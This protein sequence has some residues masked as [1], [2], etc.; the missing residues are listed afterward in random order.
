MIKVKAFFRW[1]VGR[2]LQ[3]PPRYMVIVLA[4]II[5]IS[6]GLIAVLLKNLVHI[7][8]VFIL[9]KFDINS[10][11]FLYFALP[12][13]GIFLT[14]LYVRCF[15]KDDVSHGISKVLYAIAKN[16]GHIKPHNNYSSVIASTLTVAFGGS[17]GLEA[18]VVL[19]GSSIGSSLARFFG[20][21]H[22][23]TILLVG[24]GAAGA[25]AA[26]FKAPITA[27]IFSIEVLMLDLTLS[28]VLPL[29]ISA[30][31]AAS[32]SYLLLGKQAT[33]YFSTQDPFVLSNIPLYVLLGIICGF[34]SLYFSRG[35][36]RIEHW[37]SK[38]TKVYYKIVIGGIVVGV[39]IYLFPPLYGEGYQS[40]KLILTG[41][42]TSLVN[43]SLFYQWQHYTGAFILFLL[44]VVFFKMFASA[45]TTSSGGVG[46]VFAPSL[47]LG[48]VTGYLASLL[49]QKLPFFH[50]SEKNISLVGMAGIMSGVMHAP[51][52]SVFL[53]AEITGGYSLFVPL[54]ITSAI[55]FFTIR[56]F[57]KHSIYTKRLAQKGELRT[58]NKD[59]AILMLLKPK[60]LIE[61]DFLSVL[62]E[63]TLGDLVKLVR[64][65]KRNVFPVIDSK[66]HIVGM[67]L[68]DDIRD[69]LFDG[70]LYPTTYIRELM[71]AP[72]AI[73][74]ENEPMIKIL[75]KFDETGAWNL[76]V[77]DAY[78]QYVGF[79]SKA[80][81]YAT[82]RNLLLEF[83]EE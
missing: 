48:G 82:Y 7:T 15:V 25:I 42:G 65:S 72:P 76:P 30:A 16:H 22:K 39:L 6:T 55:S 62:P 38:I 17:V 52:T 69:L 36:E 41:Q 43:G 71:T 5:G 49:F 24:C 2:T 44:F 13:V 12:L 77:V 18:P 11:N 10:S 83:S 45:L 73:V 28:S 68:L 75:N 4:V 60:P 74:L 59:K 33:F 58:H 50:V 64:Q 26:I 31:T 80:R 19:T 40:L 57:D 67:V 3:L 21:N 27:V 61:R 20:Q 9:E 14:V 32:V 47:F 1:L 56:V 29:L 54:M 23:T 51:L 37:M 53:I 70:E 81:I 35:T 78:Q 8:N 79:L 63:Q 46:G 34:V 66:N